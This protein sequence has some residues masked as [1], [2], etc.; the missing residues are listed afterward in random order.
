VSILQAN[1]VVHQVETFQNN[2]DIPSSVLKVL[3]TGSDWNQ[4]IVNMAQSR[5]R[6]FWLLDLTALIRRLVSWQQLFKSIQFLYSISSNADAKL[7]QVLS[8]YVGLVTTTKWDVECCHALDKDIILFDDTSVAGKPNGYYRQFVLEAGGD[9]IAIDGPDE[10][11]RICRSVGQMQQRQ[12]QESSTLALKFILRLKHVGLLEHP[13]TSWT[14]LVLSTLQMIQDTKS[15]S[16]LAGI[17]VDLGDGDNLEEFHIVQNAINHVLQHLQDTQ[18]PNHPIRVDMTGIVTYPFSP[19]IVDWWKELETNP[20]VD[21]I[22]V[23]AT[24][25]LVAPTGALCTRI[26]GVRES[27][28]EQ[29][30]IRR[31]YYID[32]GCYGSLY[33]GGKDGGFCPLPLLLSSRSND[34]DTTAKEE[35]EVFL[36]T[37][38]GPTCDG[39]DRVC[40]GI[41]LPMLERD[42]W[43]VFPNL[44]STG[45]L[46]TAF[47]GF[48]PPDTAYCVLEYFGK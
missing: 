1:A 40:S 22:S 17:S 31:H 46:N 11:E 15:A 23:D 28:T 10:V 47:N 2:N 6:A 30:A 37:V 25:L 44:R 41:P 24:S 34:T 29:G 8:N 36:S 39:L 16:C 12:R 33:Q 7:L 3:A 19:E 35:E 26:I 21:F 20:L 32:D 18:K 45:G 43:L 27:E 42:D 9:T 38:W 48:E 13:E 14:H 5:S 4:A